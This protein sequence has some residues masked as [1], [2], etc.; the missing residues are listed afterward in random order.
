MPAHVATELPSDLP[1]DQA[2]D[3]LRRELLDPE[4][5]QE[6]LLQRVMGWLEDLLGGLFE[7]ADSLSS[8]SALAVV[9]VVFVLALLLVVSLGRVRSAGPRQRRSS[10]GDV[11]D[12][13]TT[14]A[15]FL[16]RADRA[17]QQGD[18]R[19]CAVEAFRAAATRQVEQAVV[20]DLP[21][22]TAQDVARDVRALDPALGAQYAR[23]ADVFDAAL[24][25]HAE[26]PRQDVERLLVLAAG[27][28]VEAWTNDASS[29]VPR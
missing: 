28:R 17:L 20:D 15:E 12:P 25:G 8:P 24:Y 6:G 23:A 18:L 3:L 29:A 19:L 27:G 5:E 9:T 14:S 10:A 13:R 16:R 4:Y 11:L 21:A 7:R 22:A 1:P 2:R 26:V